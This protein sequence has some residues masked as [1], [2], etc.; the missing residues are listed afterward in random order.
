MDIIYWCNMWHSQALLSKYALCVPSFLLKAKRNLRLSYPMYKE[1]SRLHNEKIPEAY[2]PRH[3]FHF[4]SSSNF[5]PLSE[6]C[7]WQTQLIYQEGPVPWWINQHTMKRNNSVSSIIGHVSPRH[8]L[9]YNPTKTSLSIWKITLNL[10][11]HFTPHLEEYLSDLCPQWAL[12]ITFT[13]NIAAA[14]PFIFNEVRKLN[15]LKF[16][17]LL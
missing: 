13:W 6:V 4:S 15:K 14:L 5:S 3:L 8:P 2:V 10:S 17:P 16:C 12:L 11:S 7:S 1:N 9:S